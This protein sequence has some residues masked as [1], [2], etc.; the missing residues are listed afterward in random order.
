MKLQSKRKFNMKTKITGKLEKKSK[1]ELT[2]LKTV[3]VSK[4]EKITT[5]EKTLGGK[6]KIKDY[7]E[8]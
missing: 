5:I 8:G 6:I 7:V 4:E 1:L 2:K 3:A